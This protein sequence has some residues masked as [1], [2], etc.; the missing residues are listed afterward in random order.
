MRVSF[1]FSVFYDCLWI[2]ITLNKNSFSHPE[3]EKW[4]PFA[5]QI[6]LV[7]VTDHNKLQ[8]IVKAKF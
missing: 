4:N 3:I 1:S 7:L 6:F 5:Q 2:Q 8:G